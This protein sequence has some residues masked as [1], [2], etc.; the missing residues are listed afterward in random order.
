MLASTFPRSDGDGTPGFVG[1][2]ARRQ[3]LAFDTLVLVPRVSGAPV[4]EDR[5]GYRIHRFAYFPRRWEDLADGAILENARGRPSRLL[6]VVPFFV[7][8]ALAIRR[9]VREFR[10][11]VVHVHWIVPQGLAALAAA[12]R[13]PWLV[14][15]LGGD[16]YA[17]RSFPWRVLKR[18][19]LRHAAAATVMNKEMAER[20]V[21]LGMAPDRVHVM[22][23]GAN[24]DRIRAWSGTTPVPGRIVFTGRLV[25]KKGVAVLLDALRLLGPEVAWSLDVVGDGPVRAELEKRAAGLGG[26]VRFHGQLPAEQLAEMLYEGEIAAFPSV[27]ARSGDQDGLPVAMLEAMAAGRAVIASRMPGIDEAVEHGVHG[28][29]VPPGDAAALADGIRTLLT[30]PALRHELGARAA[31]RAEHYSVAA[32]GDRYVGL[33]RSVLETSTHPEGPR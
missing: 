26:Q 31:T 16:L 3:A 30:D 28:L 20:M 1:D 23:M 14:T 17:L 9:A 13:L 27:A 22:T 7:A 4:D 33:L 19:V 12:R 21:A 8:E 24:I 25:E 2:L 18:A 6:Q 15:T 32:A 10:P 11:D 29:L 5:D